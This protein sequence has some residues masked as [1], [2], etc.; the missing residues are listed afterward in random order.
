MFEASLNIRIMIKP[1]VIILGVLS[2]LLST[3]P[4]P[5]QDTFLFC[6]KG[7]VEPLT[8]NRFED[9]FTVDNNQLNRFF[10]DNAISDIEKWLP[11]SNDMDRDGDVY[12][13]RIYRVYLSEEQRL[14][15][16]MIIDSI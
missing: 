6:L 13:N 11:G 12:L 1:L 15:I 14:N 8:I 5:R 16:Q 4:I 3:E 9:G 2:L 10:I 7:E